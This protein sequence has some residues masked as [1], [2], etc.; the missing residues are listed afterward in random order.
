MHRAF[1]VLAQAL[2]LT[3]SDDRAGR[4]ADPAGRRADGCEEDV[5]G[6]E[7]GSGVVGGGALVFL[8]DGDVEDL[9]GDVGHAAGTELFGGRA[10]GAAGMVFVKYVGGFR[11]KAV[12]NGKRKGIGKYEGD[13]RRGSRGRDAEGGGF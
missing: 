4:E 7:S 1:Q 9:D 11:V 6:C 2:D 12:R 3:R 8:Y 13:C 10:D 5:E